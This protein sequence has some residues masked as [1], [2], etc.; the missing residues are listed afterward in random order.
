MYIC[1]S[2]NQ[3]TSKW[4]GRCP[5]CGEWNTIE[6]RKSLGNK[7]GKRKTAYGDYTKSYSLKNIVDN[8][9][10][11][12]NPTSLAEV[13]NV[14]GGG[15]VPGSVILL[16]GEPGIGKSTLILQLLNSIKNSLYISGEETDTQIL[17]RAQR[18]KIDLDNFNFLNETNLENVINTVQKEKPSLVIIDSIQTIY[19][20]QI[21]NEPGNIS[22]IR[23][24][25]NKLL[26]LSNHSHIPI[27]I[28]G[29]LTKD[30]SVA[31]PKTLEHLVDVVL[32][33]EGDPH[34]GYRTLRASKNRFGSTNT[35]GLFEMTGLGLT[36]IKDPTLFF[37][38]D[39][40]ENNQNTIFSLVTE[41]QRS[42][43]VEIQAL[44]SK[45][46]FGYPQRKSLGF[47][48]NRLHMNIAI[49]NKRLSLPLD[50]QDIY[51]NITGG[52]K[53]KDMAADLAVAAAI[54]NSF[55]NK[56]QSENILA[57]GEIGLNGEIRAVPFINDKVKTAINLG[58]KNIYVPYSAKTA[59]DKKFL[60]K[61]KLI[62][63][64]SEFNEMFK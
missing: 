53:V 62:K 13:N 16:S 28:I 2:C 59:I 46:A 6:E 29:H 64:L 21:A 52:L 44:V 57:I 9:K 58:F 63:S 56:T 61:I 37:L 4:A 30:G 41:G 55:Y 15:I 45:T 47:D 31:G 60:G 25:T 54:L 40:L 5:N 12:Y 42:F 10:Q 49:L 14:L 26:E 18:L 35:M 50:T 1:N 38:E 27:I 22:Q 43:V 8:N 20:G 51:L 34:Y 39:G 3:S 48:I 32:Y 11:I 7:K 24:C 23:L 19:S 33:L 36:E 17:L